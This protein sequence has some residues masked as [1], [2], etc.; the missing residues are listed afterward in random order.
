M[1]QGVTTLTYV[2]W[3]GV[4]RSPGLLTFKHSKLRPTPRPLC[5]RFP[6]PDLKYR[7]PAPLSITSP[8]CTPFMTS[9]SKFM[10]ACLLY[11]SCGVAYELR[12]GRDFGCPTPHCM[13]STPNILGHQLVWRGCLGHVSQMSCGECAERRGREKQWGDGSVGLLRAN[14]GRQEGR[15]GMSKASG[16]PGIK[17]NLL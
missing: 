14:G 17:E 7:P 10:F 15:G 3:A 5:S 6:L 4:S 9:R 16:E 1:T 2:G 11:V 8:Y 13:P 12:A